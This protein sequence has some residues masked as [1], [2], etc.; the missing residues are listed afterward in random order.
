LLVL[1]RVTGYSQ[2][3]ADFSASDSSGCTPLLVSFKDLSTGGP[4]EWSWDLGNGTLSDQKYPSTIYITPGSYSIK[5][6]IKNAAGTADSITKTSFITVYAKP[7]IDF[8]ASPSTGCVPLTINF[9]DETDPVSGT[10]QTWQWDFGDGTTDTVQNPVH[11]YRVTD[12]F[13]VTLTTSN[14]YGCTESKLK[15]SF[16]AI[17]DTVD[18]GFSYTYTSIC[19]TPSTFSFTNLSKSGNPLNYT[20][21]FGD[22]SQSTS[23]NPSYTYNTPGN[24]D[25]TL[26]AKNRSGCSDTIVKSV[27]VGTKFPNFELPP[28]GCI[29]EPVTMQDSSTPV[30]ISAIWDF[31]DGTTAT[32]L[33]ATHAYNNPGTYTVTYKTDFEDCS[34]SLKKTINIVAKPVISFSSSSARSSCFAPLTVQFSNT[35]TGANTYLWKFGDGTTS[36]DVTP[37][38]TYTTPGIF[39]VTLIASNGLGGCSDSV[40]QKAFVRIS[41]PVIDSLINLPFSGCAGATVTFGAAI[42]STEPITSF[43]WSFGDGTTSTSRAPVHTYSNLGSYDVSLIV[44]SSSGCADTLLL[45]SAVTTSSKPTANFSAVP[46]NTC[47]FQEVHFT[48]LS[49]GA[50]YWEWHFGDGTKSNDQN[51]VHKYTD[52]GSFT[53]GLIVHNGGCA[54]SVTMR[55]YIYISP[56]VAAFA[57]S[58]DCNDKMFRSFTDK[59]IGAG[60]WNWNFGDGTSSTAQN[61]TH[62]YA[63]NGI[64]NI[65]LM[66]SNGSCADT[67]TRAVAAVDENP[68][69]TTTAL[70]S[71]FCESDTIKFT[72]TNYDTSYITN[73]YWDFDDGDNA[74]GATENTTLH[75]YFRPRVY[76]PLLITTDLNGCKDTAHSTATFN[77]YGPTAIFS[78]VE[79]TCQDSVVIFNDSSISDGVHQITK[80]VWDYGDGTTDSSTSAPFSHVYRSTGTYDVKLTVYDANG[81]SDA[82]VKQGTPVITKPLADFSVFDS[83]RCTSAL[84]S[85]INA[86][87]GLS[88]NYLW[89][90]GDGTSSSLE[91]PNHA[92][93]KEGTFT[94]S[95]KV[96]DRYGCSDSIIKT[97]IVTVSNPRASFTALYDTSIACPPLQVQ[98]NN[99]SSNYSSFIWDFGDGNISTL[100]SPVHSY[101]IPGKYDLTLIVHGYGNCYDTASQSITLRGPVGTF[102]F[103]PQNGCFPQTVSFEAVAQNVVLYTWDFNDGST[104]SLK[105]N[106]TTYQYKTPG[107]YVPV[108]ILQDA[109]GCKV[110]FISK[111]TIK[112]TGVYP[113]FFANA[114]TG[115]D[116]SLVTFADSSVVSNLDGIAN[117]SWDFGDGTQT[118]GNNPIHYY[119]TPGNYTTVLNVTTDSGCTGQY[120]LP[121]SININKSPE[122]QSAFVDSVCVNTPVDFT[123]EDTAQIKDPIS[124]LWNFS[125]GDTSNT[126]NTSYTYTTPGTYNVSVIS[127][128]S[129]GCADTSQKAINILALPPVDAGIDSFLC[130]AQSITLKPTGAASYV[131]EQA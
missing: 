35:S 96:N 81:C 14:S 9:T 73:F 114:Q 117:W 108:L 30:P 28:T 80:W 94:V 17:A 47:A 100:D 109:A 36:T 68:Q 131:W 89:N 42:D 74:S 77:I 110:P 40:T 54:D 126:Q 7:V 15:S 62:T 23:K 53:V 104:Q 119:R 120:T 38:H 124:W 71:N 55:N 6:T 48:D 83:L 18:A 4:T 12:T 93:A 67:I 75:K 115:C 66:V 84:D 127:T 13:N 43:L 79:G 31:G 123:V 105:T 69:F 50:T 29:G 52:T 101:T 70:H 20:W 97:N 37:S 25:I 72:A 88:L 44:T 10:S 64:Y 33:T 92:Y 116:S 76:D 113:K 129:T 91:S 103:T 32:G 121:V 112:I 3:K 82:L 58:V 41:P 59:S 45:E 21:L 46:L 1:F 65:T 5:L 51:A 27:A 86:S 122:I 26:I 78:S 2:L 60:T 118:T 98:S 11:I 111:D 85:F 19:T 8:S 106:K 56:P 128:A 39:D 102:S 61:P 49:T 99:T 95:L 22:G 107:I 63:K 34:D 24:Y 57:T 16:I 125:N 87:K 130:L 90:F